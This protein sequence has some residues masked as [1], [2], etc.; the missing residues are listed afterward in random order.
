MC[1]ETLTV[2]GDW[3]FAE[4]QD[5]YSS[6]YLGLGFESDTLYTIHDD[7]LYHEGW[8]EISERYNNC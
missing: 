6:D 7:G 5:E 3:I 8:F 4:N 1:S 2:E